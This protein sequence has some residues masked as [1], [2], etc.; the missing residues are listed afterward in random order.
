MHKYRVTNGCDHSVGISV[1]D[2][3]SGSPDAELRDCIVTDH[4]EGMFGGRQWHKLATP[5]DRLSALDIQH[6]P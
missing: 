3:P 1:N 5:I 4:G 2:G 6:T